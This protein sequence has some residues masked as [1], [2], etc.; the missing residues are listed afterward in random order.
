MN[1]RVGMNADMR[2]E[3]NAACMPEASLV[4][5][6]KFDLWREMKTVNGIF[7]RVVYV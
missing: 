3:V 2:V 6:T 1:M 4:T 5:K 7:A